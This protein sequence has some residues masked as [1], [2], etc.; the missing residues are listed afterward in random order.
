M[1]VL[2]VTATEAPLRRRNIYSSSGL[3]I[4]PVQ[5]SGSLH[6]CAARRAVRGANEQHEAQGQLLGLDSCLGHIRVA[7]ARYLAAE[8]ALPVLGSCLQHL[9]AKGALPV[10]GSRSQHL[11][12]KGQP[13]RAGN[14]LAQLTLRPVK[15]HRLRPGRCP[16]HNC[17]RLEGPQLLPFFGLRVELW[18]GVVTPCSALCIKARKTIAAR[19]C[20][21]R[22]VHPCEMT[23]AGRLLDQLYTGQRVAL[24]K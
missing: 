24:A 4:A 9:A 15:G 16:S 10:L 23:V 21:P 20:V 6:H 13:C 18:A 11:V 7:E 14:C 1:L 8:G 12:A 2:S 5:A 17:R 3:A 22:A 19:C